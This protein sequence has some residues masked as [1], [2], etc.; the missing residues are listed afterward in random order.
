MTD[1][2][3]TTWT[4]GVLTSLIL[5]P[6]AAAGGPGWHFVEIAESSGLTYEHS[7]DEAEDESLTVVAGA[8]AGDVDG[9]GDLDLVATRGS[10]AKSRRRLQRHSHWPW[11]FPEA[12]R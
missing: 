4:A 12:G 2:P 5:L 1:R 11:P 7:W 10:A 6:G 9:D 8:A 3:G